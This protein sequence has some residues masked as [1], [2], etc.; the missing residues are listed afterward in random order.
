[1]ST[2]VVIP[3]KLRRGSATKAERD[4]AMSRPVTGIVGEAIMR[5]PLCG[6]QRVGYAFTLHLAAL[7]ASCL[8]GR[9]SHEG[10]LPPMRDV[11]QHEG[12][13]A[14]KSIRT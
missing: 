1:M 11:L 12:N 5:S 8:F 7:R 6:A 3:A 4:H 13:A 10:A 9:L 14:E 2:F